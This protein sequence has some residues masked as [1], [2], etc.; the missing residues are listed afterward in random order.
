MQNIQINRA[1]GE[2]LGGSLIVGGGWCDKHTQNKPTWRTKENFL[3]ID[4][5]PDAEPDYVLSISANSLP[6]QFL[7]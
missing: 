4:I 2:F 5:D 1:V 6:S 7:K 3:T